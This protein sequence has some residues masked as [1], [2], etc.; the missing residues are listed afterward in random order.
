MPN[1][2]EIEMAMKGLI[3]IYMILLCGDI[4]FIGG[5]DLSVM[6]KNSRIPMYSYLLKFFSDMIDILS[7]S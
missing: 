4:I 7:P 6:D 1:E 3:D 5:V 2:M